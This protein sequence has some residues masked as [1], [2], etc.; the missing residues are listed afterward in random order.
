MCVC[1]C[2]HVCVCVCVCVHECVCVCVLLC[3]CVSLPLSFSLSFLCQLLISIYLTKT[4]KKWLVV[5]PDGFQF[6][7][8]KYFYF[9]ILCVC[10]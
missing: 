6:F 10:C 3:F 1:V 8:F 9:I 7:C 2:V 4:V 5:A